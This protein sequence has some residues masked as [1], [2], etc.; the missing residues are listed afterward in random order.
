KKDKDKVADIIKNGNRQE[1][2]KIADFLL[3]KAKPIN[4]DEENLD[5]IIELFYDIKKKEDC[6]IGS[7]ESCFTN[8]NELATHITADDRTDERE[9]ITDNIRTLNC[10]EKFPT[11]YKID[12]PRYV[13]TRL[14]F[15]V[16]EA[17][18]FF[19]QDYDA[20]GNFLQESEI[21]Q[22]KGSGFPGFHKS[23]AGEEKA[24]RFP[25]GN[26]ITGIGTGIEID[27]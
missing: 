24:E 2:E 7:T 23:C 4:E 5:A 6:G 18:Q 9:E 8:K 3:N 11:V 12:S 1:R 21:K 15:L 20:K 27:S 17:M 14:S 25:A 13:L 22:I 26:V 19:Y 10:Q 16:C